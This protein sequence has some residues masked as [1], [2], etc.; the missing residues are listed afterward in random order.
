[1]IHIKAHDSWKKFLTKDREE[2]LH[3]IIENIGD[4]YTPEKEKILKFMENDLG[5]VSGVIIGLD[6]YPQKGAAT[7]RCFEVGGLESWF[8]PFKQAS[9]RNIVRLI[10]KEYN[11]IQ[12]YSDILKFSEIREEI[13][14]GS[15]PILPPNQLFKSWEEQ[16]IL[17]LNV[18]L[19][20]KIGQP[21]AHKKLWEDFSKDLFTYISEENPDIY[22]LLWGKDAQSLSRY[23]LKGN[24]VTANHPSRVNSKNPEDFLYSE[25]FKVLKGKV[26]LL[27]EL[28]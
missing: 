15:F 26:N 3:N 19:T 28:K 6:P 10:Y 7:G 2:Q 13:K 14:S 17:L 12:E 18:Y 27:G 22:W 20:T 8:T 5:K 16:G 24:I 25:S 4:D 1:M 21:K 9:L 23:I 11:E